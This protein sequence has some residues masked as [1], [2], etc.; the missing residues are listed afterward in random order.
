MFQWAAEIADA[1]AYLHSLDIVH[2]DVATRSM[3]LTRNYVLKLTDAKVGAGVSPEQIEECPINHKTLPLRW[4]ARELLSEPNPHRTK[5]S[6]VWSYGVFLWEI[7][8]CARTFHPYY[9]LTSKECVESIVHGRTLDPPATLPRILVKV[10]KRCFTEQ[11]QRPTFREINA[12]NMAPLPSFAKL[13]FLFGCYVSERHKPEYVPIDVDPPGGGIPLQNLSRRRRAEEGVGLLSHAE[14]LAETDPIVYH[15]ASIAR[16]L[17]E[18]SDA[19]LEEWENL[20]VSTS[21]P[22]GFR[23]NDDS[24]DWHLMNY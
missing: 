12:L 13:S 15:D 10:M 18:I 19:D 1:M 3:L 11:D 9:P 23:V 16:R 2:G 17:F 4:A 20:R 7:A 14:G 8:D 24:T 22:I 21:L 5:E 6:D